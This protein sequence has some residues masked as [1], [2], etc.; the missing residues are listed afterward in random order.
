MGV[1]NDISHA[2]PEIPDIETYEWLKEF[3]ADLI[4][5]MAYGHILKESF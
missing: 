5:V 4:L 1:D 3:K 2:S